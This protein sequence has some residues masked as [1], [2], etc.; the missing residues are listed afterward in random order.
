[1]QTATRTQPATERQISY[2][3][4]MTLEQAKQYGH[5]YGVCVRCS[6]TLTDEESIAAGTVIRFNRYYTNR[7]TQ[8]TYAAL[9]AKN[10]QWYPTGRDAGPV[11]L[12]QLI[13][14]LAAEN[15]TDVRVATSWETLA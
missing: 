1:M 8:Y 4:R 12:R 6:A 7:A 2:I 11:S 9:L 5:L 3:Q 15:T 10:N 13:E 14:I